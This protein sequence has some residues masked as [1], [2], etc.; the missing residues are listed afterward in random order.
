MAEPSGTETAAVFF[1]GTA[2]GS[3]EELEHI[4][5][6]LIEEIRFLSGA[7]AGMKY[8]PRFSAGLLE[9]KLKNH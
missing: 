9:I 3:L 2:M 7:E 6:S 4:Q 5:S 1:D 8:G